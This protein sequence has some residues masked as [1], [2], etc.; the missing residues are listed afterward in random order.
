MPITMSSFTVMILNRIVLFLS[1]CAKIK[2]WL[3][4]SAD[5]RCQNWDHPLTVWQKFAKYR[6][7]EKHG[8]TDDR[9]S[10]RACKSIDL[11]T[12]EKA[13]DEALMACLRYR[14]RGRQQHHSDCYQGYR[15]RRPFRDA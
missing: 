6:G 4:T 3:A 1:P 9:P 11:V 15:G 13:R 12:A 5:K 7:S 8:T 14:A 10:W 2:K